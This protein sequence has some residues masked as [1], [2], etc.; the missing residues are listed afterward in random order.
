MSVGLLI[1]GFVY[2]VA[3]MG[4]VI[5]FVNYIW[6]HEDELF[7][8]SNL[9]IKVIAICLCI[10]IFVVMVAPILAPQ[11]ISYNYCELNSI[12][13]NGDVIYAQVVN[14]DGDSSYMFYVNGE[15]GNVVEVVDADYITIIERDS[16]YGYVT[17]AK[18]HH[19]M[20]TLIEFDTYTSVDS[21]CVPKGTISHQTTYL[22]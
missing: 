21:I 10:L 1:A 19:F 6:N 4:S 20:N 14:Y 13:T 2:F 8:T 3:C 17:Y 12:S 16:D 7:G 5:I 22:N 9:K 11:D 18:H 15:N